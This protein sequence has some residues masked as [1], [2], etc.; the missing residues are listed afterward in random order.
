MCLDILGESTAPA[1]K[2]E[3]LLH[4]A[5]LC[6]DVVQE[7]RDHFVDVSKYTIL[8]NRLVISSVDQ[9]LL[10]GMTMNFSSNTFL[11]TVFDKINLCVELS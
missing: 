9:H 2:I 8:F 3:G 7:N 1:K 4:L 5:E 10:Q 6:I 11:T